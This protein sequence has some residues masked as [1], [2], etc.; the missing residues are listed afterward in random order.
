MS[1]TRTIDL[2]E[3]PGAIVWTENESDRT[4]LVEGAGVLDRE[5]FVEAR[6]EI[7]REVD[8]FDALVIRGLSDTERIIFPQDCHD[9]FLA[10]D[11]DIRTLE[12][13]NVDTRQVQNM[14]RMFMGVAARSL[15]L[16]AFDTS[17]VTDMSEMFSE[18]TAYTLEIGSWDVS[19][20]VTMRGMFSRCEVGS[21]DLSRWDTSHVEDMSE[22]F[23]YTELFDLNLDGFN[24]SAVTSMKEMFLSASIE[25]M[26][27]ADEGFGFFNTANVKDFSGMFQ[28]YNGL[29]PHVEQWD[30]SSLETS[31]DMFMDCDAEIDFDALEETEFWF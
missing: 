8:Q 25:Q 29:D 10:L 21:L 18:C 31:E 2:G 15:N 13:E 1:S 22:M 4:I 5:K 20:V 24:T 9:L 28:Y 23:A 14:S 27:H 12:I 19:S 30:T 16:D 17:S 3:T 6:K 11:S 26:P 7:N